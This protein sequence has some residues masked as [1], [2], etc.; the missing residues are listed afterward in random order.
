MDSKM[1][2]DSRN[3]P[4]SE[5]SVS[6]KLAEIQERCARLRRESDNPLTLE[7]EKPSAATDTHNPYSVLGLSVE[8]TMAGLALGDTIIEAHYN[9]L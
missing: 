1:G 6:H 5:S 9:N 3:V 7:D 8:D 4:L 2:K